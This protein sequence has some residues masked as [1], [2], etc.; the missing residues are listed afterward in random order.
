[1]ND[2]RI[3]GKQLVATPFLDYV[4]M[5]EPDNHSVADVRR[6]A[7]ISPSED[8]SRFLPKE[9]CERVI[10]KVLNSVRG[11]GE[12]YVDVRSCWEGGLRWARNRTNL[13]SNRRSITL[14]VRRGFSG[15][16]KGVAETNQL[17]DVSL[18]AAVR[19]AERNARWTGGVRTVVGLEVST[20]DLGEPKVT[21]WGESTYSATDAMRGEIGRMLSEEAEAKSMLSAGYIEMR[22]GQRAISLRNI[23]GSDVIRYD[24]YTTSQCSMTTR[25]A[26]GVGSGWAGLSSYDWAAIDGKAL[27]MRSLENSIA[28][29]N[30]VMIEPGRYDV[31]LE[32]QAVYQLVKALV[33][34]LF[35]E[36]S[37]SPMGM[38]YLGYDVDV[39]LGRSKLGLRIVDPRVTIRHD[40]T[41][42]MEGVVPVG[43]LLGS[44]VP[45]M[46]V[47]WIENGVLSNLAYNRNYALHRLNEN[48]GVLHRPAFRMEGGSTTIDEMVAST[49][50]GIRVTRFSALEVLDPKSLLLTGITRD[51]LWLIE[52]GKIS[53]PIKNFRFT[54]SPLFMLNQ[55]ESLGVPVPVFSDKRDEPSPYIVPPIKAHDFSFTSL[56]DAV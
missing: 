42:P 44:V 43:Y 18:E 16:G 20:P 36:D 32:P 54:E 52:N 14:S 45:F 21:I 24:R 55:L 19:A 2:F 12:T 50:R 27:A 26:K 1:M 22:A 53:K 31:V 7:R 17:D 33:D 23:D 8:D 25:D 34:T 9:T 15:S 10:R 38:H 51:G 11:G 13:A 35:R 4:Y 39:D 28:S 3:H 46:P 56:V 41:H 30:P 6:F 40:P 47:V 5:S 48:L 49:K 29:M 37:E